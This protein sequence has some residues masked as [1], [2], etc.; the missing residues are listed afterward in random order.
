MRV[1]HSHR[2]RL[3]KIR[4]PR[5]SFTKLLLIITRD[6]SEPGIVLRAFYRG[7]QYNFINQTTTSRE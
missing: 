2:E 5:R 1:F 7:L 4:G 6:Y 3:L